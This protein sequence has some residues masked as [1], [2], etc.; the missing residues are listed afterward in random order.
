MKVNQPRLYK[1]NIAAFGR[2]TLWLVK[3][4]EDPVFLTIAENIPFNSAELT[5]ASIRQEASI[6]DSFI[7]GSYGLLALALDYQSDE[8]PFY[9]VGDMPDSILLIRGDEEELKEF[10]GMDKGVKGEVYET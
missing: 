2:V 10:F 9:N 5:F 7:K 6:V 3:G 4:E 8:A 1:P